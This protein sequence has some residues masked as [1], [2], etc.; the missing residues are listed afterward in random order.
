MIHALRPKNLL[1]IVTFHS[2]PFA[3]QLIQASK[4]HE[5]IRILDNYI[6]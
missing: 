5:S 2:L 6:I 1:Q 3:S 4:K